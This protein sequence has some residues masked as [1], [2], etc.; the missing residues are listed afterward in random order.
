MTKSDDVGPMLYD[1]QDFFLCLSVVY[2]T[3]GTYC[4]LFVFVC[5]VSNIVGPIGPSVCV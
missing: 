1:P 2:K 3:K 5:S 4:V